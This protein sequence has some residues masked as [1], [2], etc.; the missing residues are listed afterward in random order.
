MH[1]SRCG[2]SHWIWF[3][4]QKPYFSSLFI[5]ILSFFFNLCLYFTLCMG[6]CG[7]LTGVY[8]LRHRKVKEFCL[9][10]HLCSDLIIW[11]STVAWTSSRAWTWLTYKDIWAVIIILFINL[12]NKVII[13]LFKFYLKRFYSLVCELSICSVQVAAMGPLKL[14][15][16]LDRLWVSFDSS[17]LIWVAEVFE[18][19]WLELWFEQEV[20][21]LLQGRNWFS[22]LNST[23]TL[24][25][26]TLPTE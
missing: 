10:N 3:T 22:A 23:D 19:P 15:W 12:N 20:T 13:I 8:A 5:S 16:L 17:L 14:R 2:K 24:C 4:R 9:L 25:F 18:L 1:I 21:K 6:N 11:V 7:V 26:L